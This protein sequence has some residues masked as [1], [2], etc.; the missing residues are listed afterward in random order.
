MGPLY[1]IARLMALW[2]YLFNYIK[3]MKDSEKYFLWFLQLKN[4]AK[5]YK[6]SIASYNINSKILQKYIY[7]QTPYSTT[8]VLKFSFSPPTSKTEKLTS[9]STPPYFLLHFHLV[10]IEPLMSTYIVWIFWKLQC[11][12]IFFL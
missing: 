8:L 11:N 1:F 5:R 6:L 2:P 7:L 3:K 10:V 9:L 4:F 12:C